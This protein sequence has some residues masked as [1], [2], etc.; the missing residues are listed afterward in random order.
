MDTVMGAGAARYF[1]EQAFDARDAVVLLDIDGTLVP[2]CGTRASPAVVDKVR[3]LETRGNEVYLC[4]NSRRAGYAAR[5]GALGSQLGVRVCP[6]PARKPSLRALSGLDLAGRSLVIVGDKDLTDGL[7]AR[8]AGAQFV[9]VRRKID[10]GDR[11]VSRLTS[12]MDDV[13]GPVAL[14]LWD[15]VMGQGA[16]RCDLD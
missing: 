8:R 11:A 14:F 15:M 7:L 12:W 4:S 2:D 10:P 3:E 9:K 16:R 5:I 6:V 1:E 13:F